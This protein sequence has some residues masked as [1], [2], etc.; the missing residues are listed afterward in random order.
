MK[1]YGGIGLYTA[2]F[3]RN[4]LWTILSVFMGI[5]SDWNMGMTWELRLC[6]I[7]IHLGNTTLSNHQTCRSCHYGSSLILDIEGWRKHLVLSISKQMNV[8]KLTYPTTLHSCALFKGN[9]FVLF[10]KVHWCNDLCQG[11]FEWQLSHKPYSI[12]MWLHGSQ[13]CLFN[14]VLCFCGCVFVGFSSCPISELQLV[15]AKM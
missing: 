10:T 8:V 3:T 13:S 14:S 6:I 5:L 2:W 4:H 9:V 12:L 11:V 1:G 15:I 7:A